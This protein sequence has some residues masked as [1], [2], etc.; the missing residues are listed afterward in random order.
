M[1]DENTLLTAA[2]ARHLLRRTGFGAP[3][4]EVAKIVGKPRG[5]VVDALL[6]FEPTD[7]APTGTDQVTAFG[8]VDYMLRT[9]TPIQEKLVLFWHDHFATDGTKVSIWSAMSR[10]QSLLR[11]YCKGDF[12]KLVKAVNVDFAM[13]VFLDT[14]RNQ[15]QQPN[16]NYAREMQEL[17][18]LGVRDV[19]G[20]LNYSQDDVTQ[21]A[22]AFSGWTTTPKNDVVF[23]PASHDYMKDY[24][25]RGPKVIYKTAGG[26]GPAGRDFAANGEGAPEVD[27]VV[28][29]I[30]D[31]TD[32]DGKKTV[33]RF[34]AGKLF[35]YF[36]QPGIKRRL[37]RTVVPIIDQIIATSRFDSTWDIKALLRALFVHDTFYVTG[38]PA[39][40]EATTKKSVRWPVDYVVST[41][42]LLGVR[43]K[44]FY[45]VI[46]G[47]DRRGI[48]LHLE[49]MGQVLLR[50]PSVFGWD[51]ETAWVSSAT[52]LARYKFARDV[53]SVEGSWW[54]WD[55]FR[56]QDLIDINL[57]DP[58]AIVDAVLEAL[59]V[60]DQFTPGA[61]AGL[62]NYL[63]D[64]GAT[65]SLN[66]HDD[67]VR[68]TKLHGLFA[69][70]LQSPEYQLC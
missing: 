52:L 24:P 65:P 38:A 47:G 69:L 54:W 40:F 68:H 4:G 7:Y 9:A 20:R 27:T 22:R 56:P 8:W 53:T 43:P 36:A 48:D 14:A 45:H 23:D 28:D 35:T 46:E 64:H 3:P 55:G 67:N 16:E 44:G 34:V 18:T 30:F 26:F 21:I 13:I 59:G 51:W 60:P 41:L 19:A 66:L 37:E 61:H 15:K 33:A 62:V 63:T 10:Q 31:H 32:S 58:S 1:G 50:P 42:R 6:A 49:D 25:A 70:V 17:F 11:R 5:Q 12:K 39:P 29:I 57:T 2:D